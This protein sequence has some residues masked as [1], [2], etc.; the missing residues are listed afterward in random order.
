MDV[1]SEIKEDY[2][3]KLVGQ[4][5]R[6]D[7]RRFDEYRK[8]TVGNNIASTA[9]GSARVKFGDTDVLVGVKMDVGEPFP[10]TPD[11]GILSTNAELVPMASPTFES[12]PPN[13]DAIELARVV[14]RGIRESEAIDLEKLCIIPKEKVWIV[15]I[16]IY[17]LDYNGNFFDASALGAL[18]ALKNTVVPAKKFNLGED[19]PLPLKNLPITCTA[20]KLGKALLFDSCL[21]EEKVA[22]AR[23]SITTDINGDIRAMQKGF[24]GAFL[25]DEIRQIVKISKDKGKEL[26]EKFFR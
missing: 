24:R 1:I 17:V 10:D 13:E 2:I 19:Y 20:V 26:R 11:T 9:E 6:I 12:G 25:I 21:D 22:E 23:L 14:D 16:D 15:F 3:Y 7:G 8:I 5:K 4:G 18:F